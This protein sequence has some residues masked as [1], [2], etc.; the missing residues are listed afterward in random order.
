MDIL[1]YD[2]FAPFFLLHFCQLN[3]TNAS[4][5]QAPRKSF[6]QFSSL[7]YLVFTFSF[8]RF[9]RIVHI[10]KND[11]HLKLSSSIIRLLLRQNYV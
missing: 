5:R 9:E 11:F 2:T 1:L 6:V 10:S 3:P 7:V 4:Q 8:D